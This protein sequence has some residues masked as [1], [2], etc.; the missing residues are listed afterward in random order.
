MIWTEKT[1]LAA[2][3]ALTAHKNHVDHLGVPLA[4]HLMEVASAQNSESCTVTALFHDYLE[5]VHPEWDKETFRTEFSQYEFSEKILDA[6]WL[7]RHEPNE[8]YEVYIRRI[9]ESGNE[10][11]IQVKLA[12]L[13][14]NGNWAR[15]LL[16]P[17]EGMRA[18]LLKKYENASTLLIKTRRENPQF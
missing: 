3:V 1:L 8:P 10:L 12:D 18:R 14:S 13:A 7:L 11:A 4:C 5:D 6:L 2:Q 17:D 9:C 16:I 15:L